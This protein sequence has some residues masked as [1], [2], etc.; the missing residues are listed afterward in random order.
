MQRKTIILKWL[1]WSENNYR[2]QTFIPTTKG[3]SLL[4]LNKNII[5]LQL[6]VIE[7]PAMSQALFEGAEK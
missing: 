2:L 4:Y 3:T 7:L 1:H 5:L 6:I